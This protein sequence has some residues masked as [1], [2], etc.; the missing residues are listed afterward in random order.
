MGIKRLVFV[1]FATVNGVIISYFYEHLTGMYIK[2]NIWVIVVYHFLWM[3]FG[4]VLYKIGRE[5][6]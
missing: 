2:G 1:S 4:V 5:D 3:I 6:G